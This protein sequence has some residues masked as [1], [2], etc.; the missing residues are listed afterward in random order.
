MSHLPEDVSYGSV[1]GHGMNADELRA[2]T[3]LDRHFVQDLNVDPALPLATASIDGACLCVGVQY[4]QQ[5]L[6]VFRELGRVL[7]PGA[8]VA[9][10]FSNRCFPTKAVAI[11]QAADHR[12]HQALVSLYLER[13]GFVSVEAGGRA[14]RSG[15]PLWWV[16]GQAPPGAPPG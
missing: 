1:I 12:G 7:R 11:W 14:P 6:A 13:A 2:N 9:V 16:V 3:R 5:P 15:D 10:T 8:P 4:L